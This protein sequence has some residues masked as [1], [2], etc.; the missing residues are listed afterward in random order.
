MRSRLSTAS[1]PFF[2]PTLVSV[3][4]Q[5]ALH[6]DSG[7]M[8]GIGVELARWDE[9]FNFRD[10]DGGGSRHH[11]IEVARGTPVDQIAVMIALPRAHEREIGLERHL[12]HV[13]TAVD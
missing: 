2:D 13:V 9:R 7:G 3:A 8:H 1:G 11:R 5:N 6:E 4:F 12:E 10:G